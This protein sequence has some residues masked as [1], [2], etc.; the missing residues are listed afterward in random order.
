MPT[1]AD[2]ARTNTS[3]DIVA[4]PA[5]DRVACR[6]ISIK[7]KGSLEFSASSRFP[8]QNSTAMF[9]ANPSVPLINMLIMIDWGTT[10]AA[11]WTS[12]DSYARVL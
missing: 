4:A 1:V 9:M 7:A 5:T 11:L 3:D 12:S 6:N 2:M 8:M 10:T